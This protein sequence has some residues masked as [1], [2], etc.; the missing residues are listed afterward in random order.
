MLADDN[1]TENVTADV[2]GN[3]LKRLKQY[4]QLFLLANLSITI[5]SNQLVGKS[6]GRLKLVEKSTGRL[7][8]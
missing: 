1:V 6:T 7:S 2:S 5:K 3:F 4:P 8:F